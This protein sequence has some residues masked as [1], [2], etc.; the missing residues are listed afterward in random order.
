MLP[1]LHQEKIPKAK[2]DVKNYSELLLGEL[3]DSLSELLPLKDNEI[4]LIQLIRNSGEIRPDLI[5][6]DE[7][8]SSAIKSHP[9]IL[10]KIKNISKK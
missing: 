10:W 1:V 2:S 5:T 4:E 7:I 9:A 8:V 6:A 3:H